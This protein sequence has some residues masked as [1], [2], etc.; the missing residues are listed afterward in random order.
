MIIPGVHN[1]AKVYGSMEACERVLCRLPLLVPEDPDENFPV[2]SSHQADT[3][4]TPAM[5]A[6]PGH[7]AK[8]SPAP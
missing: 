5:A 4:E 8:I 3:K 6:V 7:P 2:A 1:S